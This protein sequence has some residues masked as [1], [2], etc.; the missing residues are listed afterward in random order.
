MSR[1]EK[2]RVAEEDAD[3]SS[4]R[5]SRAAASV[6]PFAA[7][8]RERRRGRV[9][10]VGRWANRYLHSTYDDVNAEKKGPRGRACAPTVPNKSVSPPR[11]LFSLEEPLESVSQ[12]RRRDRERE[13]ETPRFDVRLVVAN[14]ISVLLSSRWWE[15]ASPTVVERRVLVV[16]EDKRN[17]KR[18]SSTVFHP[19]LR[20]YSVTVSRCFYEK[21]FES[22]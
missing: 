18:S 16:S 13:R 9:V 17:D 2:K 1:E 8:K 21:Q 5:L 11:R 19:L 3:G 14:A 10:S 7:L 20:I 6:A 12:G 15:H 4:E 22:R